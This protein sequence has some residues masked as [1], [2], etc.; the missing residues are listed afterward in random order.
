MHPPRRGKL[1][2]ILYANISD[3]KMLMDFLSKRC[4]VLESIQNRALNNQTNNKQVVEEKFKVVKNAHLCINCLRSTAHQAKLC[5][6]G[7]CRKCS[8]KHNTLLHTSNSNISESISNSKKEQSISNSKIS[9]Q[10]SN[11]LLPLSTAIVNAYDSNNTSH[12][13]RILLDSGSQINF[14][15]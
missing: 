11:V 1:F 7:T 2:S 15:I 3:L 4:Q 6:S 13:C 9:N 5:N 10:D 12:S 14:I 8:K